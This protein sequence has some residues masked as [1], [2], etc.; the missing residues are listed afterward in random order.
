MLLRVPML[1]WRVMRVW[2]RCRN[3]IGR[4]ANLSFKG[5]LSITCVA[6]MEQREGLGPQPL[7][8]VRVALSQHTSQ[9][10]NNRKFPLAYDKIP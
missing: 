8:D 7:A 6:I 1:A 3:K 9:V 4:D 2:R 5:E 10:E